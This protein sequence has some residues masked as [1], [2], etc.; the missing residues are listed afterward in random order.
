MNKSIV[1]RNIKKVLKSAEAAP[2]YQTIRVV[3]D[4]AEDRMASK[5]NTRLLSCISNYS[6]SSSSYY[7]S[8]H[9]QVK[10]FGIENAYTTEILR[11]ILA[12]LL[13]DIEDDL[14]QGFVD[15]IQAEVFNDFI[16]MGEHLLQKGYKDAAAVMLGGVLEETL[17]S[18]SLKHGL[19]IKNGKKYIT[20]D[21]L[22]T[23]LYKE[24]VYS[25]SQ[26][27]A[28]V[29]WLG[30]RNDAAHGEY[31]RF[32]KN[33]VDDFLMSLTNFISNFT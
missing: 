21:E 30:L 9:D 22:S 24:E 8:A 19:I 2:V 23:N 28:V 32:K 17:R 26:H 3:E 6:K 4:S 18:M 5:H 15:I 25:L 7:K 16:E 20:A 13:E 12:G 14:M 33:Q 10:K 31:E 27:K 29:S 1:I 11:G